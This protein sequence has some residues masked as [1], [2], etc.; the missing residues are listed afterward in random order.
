MKKW[1]S[2]LFVLGLIFS[3]MPVDWMEL[4]AN[5]Y[6]PSVKD[7]GITWTT[8]ALADVVDYDQ[9][10]PSIV[11][12][13]PEKN[14]NNAI[15]TSITAEVQLNLLRA[16]IPEG[17]IEIHL[18][19]LLF[20]D[21]NGNQ[22]GTYSIGLS[23]VPTGSGSFYYKESTDG[24]ELI[25][26]NFKPIND[27]MQL[28]FNITYY[29]CNT[30]IPAQK[31]SILQSGSI[32]KLQ[33]NLRFGNDSTV[34][35]SNQLSVKY[36]TKA[37]LTEVNKEKHKKWENWQDAWGAKPADADQYSYVCW[38][39]YGK[40]DEKST[41]P[42]LI[43]L[44]DTPSAGELVGWYD[45]ETY[46]WLNMGGGHSNFQ[47]STSLTNQIKIEE[48]VGT[49]TL[50]ITHLVLRYPKDTVTDGTNLENQIKVSIEDAYQELDTSLNQTLDAKAAYS[51]VDIHFTAPEGRNW[52]GKQYVNQYGVPTFLNGYL[53][54]IEHT[55][56]GQPLPETQGNWYNYVT[57]RSGQLTVEQ[58]KDINDPSNYEKVYYTEENTDDFVAL[59]N[60]RL[61][62]ED[63]EFTELCVGYEQ[64]NLI[65]NEDTGVA[66]SQV[67]TDYATWA[68]VYV[69]IQKEIDGTWN[70]FGTVTCTDTGV[71]HFVG[72]NG[73]NIPDVNKNYIKLPEGV[74]GVQARHTTNCYSGKLN[75]NVKMK[76]HKTEHIAK[77]AEGKSELT[78]T[79]VNTERCFNEK[80]EWVDPRSA[81][82]VSGTLEE[83][84]KERDAIWNTDGKYS[85]HSSFQ[86]KLLP[87]VQES[88][89]RKKVINVKNDANKQSFI[90][91]YQAVALHGA[92]SDY[93][94]PYEENTDITGI[95]EQRQGIFYDLLPKGMYVDINDLKVSKMGRRGNDIFDSRELVNSTVELKENW[96]G[97]GRTMMIVHVD[98]P[99]NEDNHFTYLHLAR[100]QEYESGFVL[101]YDAYY[102]WES[103]F[104]YGG[105]LH[106]SIAY[107]T[108]NPEI[109]SGLQDVPMDDF[110]DKE[111]MR[112]LDGDGEFG[113]G[114]TA[115]ANTLYTDCSYQIVGDV[116]SELGYF[117]KV[118][119]QQDH[120]YT[121]SSNVLSGD[122]Y[123]YRLSYSANDNS[124]NA[125]GIV[126][127]DILETKDEGRDKWQGNFVGVDLSI[128]EAKGIAPVVYYST[129]ENLMIN[130]DMGDQSGDADLTNTTIW[131]TSPPSDLYKVRAIAIDLSK[132][133]DGSDFIL[134][135]RQQVSALIYMQA[136]IEGVK[137]LMEKNAKAY[138]S[139][140]V[141]SQTQL[142]SSDWNSAMLETTETT[143]DIKLPQISIHKESDPASGS[144]D[145][146]TQV[147]KKDPITYD[148]KITNEEPSLYLNDI[149]VEDLI[150][151]GLEID[152]DN[153]KFY[154]GDDGANAEFIS[155]SS[156]ADVQQEGQKLIFSIPS[157]MKGQSIHLLIPTMVEDNDF[158]GY[159]ENTAKIIQVNKHP[160]E[161]V[162]ETT[163]HEK[164]AKQ[165]NFK[166]TKVNK[167]QEALAQAKFA[168]YGLD[169][170]DPAHSHGVLL[171]VDAQGALI[172]P[173]PC[174][175]KL[176]D[177]TSDA[178]GSVSFDPIDVEREYRLI[179]Y[180][181]P[182]GYV[183]PKGQWVLN[184]DET[185]AQ[186]KV[187]GSI[188]N[189]P[190]VEI[191]DDGSYE[192][193]NYR[194]QEIP[195]TGSDGI[196]WFVYLG[197]GCM[198][199][200]MLWK[201]IQRKE[202]N[203]ER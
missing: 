202:G 196:Q 99:A 103:Y 45:I 127:Y 169:C 161:I 14:T 32:A 27:V 90:F 29:S 160:Q 89:A 4:K 75:T 61:T 43:K 117:K 143:V 30:S 107:Q 100:G 195:I 111:W 58:G 68:P 56:I 92:I 186:I 114:S 134:G 172:T 109:T 53:D 170:E 147:Q 159:Y 102:S 5:N 20:Q 125:K 77:L 66:D 142:T 118:K 72:V 26:T 140:W 149:L 106:N 171:E 163:Y 138:N 148:L 104:D 176:A 40:I 162:S 154:L 82:A 88:L 190:A 166:F 179:E 93:F 123:S 165:A 83:Q 197:V 28:K 131:S 37:A 167:G 15:G 133:K 81:S 65:V 180:E 18:P 51:Y 182:I 192:I 48:Q 112:D 39:I 22:I 120:Q 164:N 113:E 16:D 70:E 60:E 12:L 1:M 200:G 17:T 24:K 150:P 183:L 9:N 6:P 23:N 128:V 59:E 137:D 115:P 116:A 175:K 54:A 38:K 153:I 177:A 52:I 139:S 64:Q 158:Y 188:A 126:F 189:P 151:K 124:A 94:H 156:V 69:Y 62:K 8:Q 2:V 101:E 157:L 31:P 13:T 36:H 145:A 19:K 33:A 34:Y 46:N 130:K 7:F 191:K 71:F 50:F 42:F 198:A 74:V 63:Y 95:Q 79:N 87:T 173:S 96:R 85:T 193:Y 146:P 110:L 84:V 174:W 187:S 168:L 184:Y 122:Y 11:T 76:L 49:A 141:R 181:A 91:H 178:D 132:K 41:R 55:E 105:N 80:G 129:T 119:N 25:V 201:K 108:M 199:A 67:N 144:A 121:A 10:D 135:N 3:Q 203:K 47:N 185:S 86:V 57:Y 78:V 194:P 73:Q 97:T 21:R 98:V 44:E 155:N 136:P 152:F 35:P